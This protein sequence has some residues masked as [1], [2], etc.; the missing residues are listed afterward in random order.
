[1]VNQVPNVPALPKAPQDQFLQV[2][3]RTLVTVLAEISFRLNQ[4]LQ[5]DGSEAMTAPLVLDTFTVATRPTAS[6]WT[7]GV[8]FVSDAAG[9]SKFQ[10]SDGSSW[11]SLG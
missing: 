11:V 2:L 7:G 5:K 8:I 10:G 1:M 4:S 9:G 6:D 3:V